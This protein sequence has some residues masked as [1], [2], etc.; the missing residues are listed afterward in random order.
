MNVGTPKRK[1]E[2]KWTK[3]EKAG[4]CSSTD[5]PLPWGFH[6]NLAQSII[7]GQLVGRRIENCCSSFF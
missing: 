3:G 4:F 6:N 7:Q 1:S 5:P 2:R